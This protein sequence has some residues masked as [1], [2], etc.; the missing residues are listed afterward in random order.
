MDV[1]TLRNDY[2]SGFTELLGRPFVTM[3]MSAT[4]LRET[5]ALRSFLNQAS[6][7]TMQ[8]LLACYNATSAASSME[9]PMLA[10]L[11]SLVGK[12][13]SVLSPMGL[14][15]GSWLLSHQS[16]FQKALTDLVSGQP[17]STVF[18]DLLAATGLRAP[19]EALSCEQCDIV[20][21]TD[22]ADALKALQAQDRKA[23]LE[24]LSH[25]I[26]ALSCC[27]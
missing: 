12:L 18:A 4:Q 10:A 2:D 7:A 13:S 16:Q 27:E 5:R 23:A 14:S 15:I 1:Q 19:M 24:S 6:D 25:A 3:R 21:K 11:I 17:L 8:Q 22:I 26:S 9:S 20:A